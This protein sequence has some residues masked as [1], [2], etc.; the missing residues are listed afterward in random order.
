[1]PPAP[2]MAVFTSLKTLNEAVASE[3]CWTVPKS[4][5]VVL[6]AS[7]AG[8]RRSRKTGRC[9]P[10]TVDASMSACAMAGPTIVFAVVRIGLLKLSPSLPHAR[11]EWFGSFHVLVLYGWFGLPT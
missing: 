4:I 5:V 8:V 7:S 1:M 9:P 3:P 10:F 11:Y 2:Q 6:A